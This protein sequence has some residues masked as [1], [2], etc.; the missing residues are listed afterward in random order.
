MREVT[1]IA[2]GDGFSVRR[3]RMRAAGEAWTDPEISPGYDVNF[4]RTGAFRARVGGHVLL[5][6]P[7]V[8]YVGHPGRELSIAHAP[9][10]QDAWTSIALAE[11]TVHELTGGTRPA[12]AFPVTGRLA[13]QHRMLVARRH[14]EAFELAERTARLV[15]EL[16]R[17]RPP[18]TRRAAAGLVESAREL[19]ALDPTR[20]LR[21]VAREAGCSPYHL[22]RAFHRET[23]T[24]LTRY[25]NRIRVLMALEAVEGG[26]RDLAGLAAEL[27]FADHAHLTR[28]VRQECGHPPAVLRRMLARAEPDKAD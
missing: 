1:A 12:V 27:G 7:A 11:D 17:G 10:R 15:G 24:T 28:T 21:D 16:L 8:A 9:G 4:I 5:A 23:G 20:G 13:V 19:L 25:R 6:D 14:A 26:R 3:V 18:G 22:S 2:D